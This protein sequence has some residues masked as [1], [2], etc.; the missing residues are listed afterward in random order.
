[1]RLQTLRFV[2][3][4]SFISAAGATPP[5]F[6]PIEITSLGGPQGNITAATVMATS[7]EYLGILPAVPL[8]YPIVFAFIG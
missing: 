5:S 6:T 4:A 2:A 1:M 7:P 3:A 8:N